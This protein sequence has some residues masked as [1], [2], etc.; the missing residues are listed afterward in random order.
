MSSKGRRRQIARERYMD[1]KDESERNR[2]KL[3]KIQCI[4]CKGE[5][6]IELAKESKIVVPSSIKTTREELCPYC[7]GPGA[8]MMVIPVEH[9]IGLD[10]VFVV[11]EEQNKIILSE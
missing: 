4:L 11:S 7:L 3:R 5:G 6:K 1:L 2:T 8:I 10:G 9:D